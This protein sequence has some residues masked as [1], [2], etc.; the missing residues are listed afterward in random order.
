M[1][2]V[3]NRWLGG[4]LTN[5]ETISKSIKKLED[6]EESLKDKNTE[7]L[8][9]KEILTIRRAYEK[10]DRGLGGIREMKKLPDAI[11]II[12]V[13]LIYIGYYNIGINIK[14]FL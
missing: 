9:K 7:N 12:D 1:P 3:S 2:Y 13:S 14:V 6:L 11:F 8:S 10:L 5:N 4:T